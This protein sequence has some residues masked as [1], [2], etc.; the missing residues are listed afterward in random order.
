ML[1]FDLHA[2]C[3]PIFNFFET[4]MAAKIDRGKEAEKPEYVHGANHAEVEFAVVEFC[5]RGDFHSAAISGRVG[6]CGKDRWQ[7]GGGIS[8]AGNLHWEWREAQKFAWSRKSI[9]AVC[10]EPLGKIVGPARNFSIKPNPSD[11]AKIVLTWGRWPACHFVYD[12]EI[13]RAS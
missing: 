10:S 4:E 7:K 11:A 5:L 8:I 9:S 13:N 1:G 2:R 12:A 6:D 3:L